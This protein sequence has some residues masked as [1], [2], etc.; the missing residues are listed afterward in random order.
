MK[1]LRLLPLLLIVLALGLPTP[2]HAQSDAPYIYYYSDLLK[3]WVIE[4][5]DGTDGRVIGQGIQQADFYFDDMTSTIWCGRTQVVGC[6][7]VRQHGVVL[8]GVAMGDEQCGR[9]VQ[10]W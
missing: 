8:V 5:A 6:P 10:N 7:G 1:S 4:R 3:G 2:T 9:M